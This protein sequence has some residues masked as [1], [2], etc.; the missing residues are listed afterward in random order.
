VTVTGPSATRPLANPVVRGAIAVPSVAALLYG[1]LVAEIVHLELF[2]ALTVA[3]LLL[4]RCGLVP[5]HGGQS[6]RSERAWQVLSGT[7]GVGLAAP[8]LVAAIDVDVERFSLLFVVVLVIGAYTYPGRLRLPLCLWLLVVWA[9]TLWWGGVT[10]AA[11]LTLHL[12][13]GVLVL[14]TSIRTADALAA[15]VGVEATTRAEAEQRA[16]L[17]SS[18]LRTNSLEPND[19]L[20]AVT[21]GLADAGFDAVAIREFDAEIGTLR[22]V[23]GSPGHPGARPPAPA[24]RRAGWVVGHRR[25]DRS[26]RRGRRLRLPPR[27]H[28]ARASAAGGDRCPCRR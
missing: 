15:A 17:L 13:G 19:V 20:R 18:V 7:I 3:A 27:S 12:G 24:P 25:R 14:G 26:S 4:A 10:D 8:F 11:V 22:L 2:V 6:A 5:G 28:P 23:M 21:T 1:V 9:A 16:G